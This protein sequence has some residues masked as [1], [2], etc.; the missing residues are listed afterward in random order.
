MHAI[1]L[2]QAGTQEYC[3]H[4]QQAV[5]CVLSLAQNLAP[6]T[7]PYKPKLSKCRVTKP[8]PDCAGGTSQ[9]ALNQQA[10]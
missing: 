9:P 10:R 1:T 5:D 8:K 3:E 6:S 2:V 7:W 4:D